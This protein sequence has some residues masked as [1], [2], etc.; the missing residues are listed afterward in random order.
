MP[1]KEEFINYY[2]TNNHSRAETMEYF[3]ISNHYL[4]RCIQEYGCIKHPEYQ[5]FKPEKPDIVSKEELYQYYVIENHTYAETI[6]HFNLGSSS[7]PNLLD[8]YNINKREIIEGWKFNI[9]VQDIY[10]Y[11]IVENHTYKE[12]IDHFNIGHSVFY[13]YYIKNYPELIKPKDLMVEN[14]GKSVLEKYGVKG[15]PI[16]HS[17]KKCVAILKGIFGEGEIIQQYKDERY[18]FK[19]DIYIKKLDLF[20]E[21]NFNWTHGKHR[22]NPDNK[23]DVLLLERW[24]NKSKGDDYYSSAIVVWTER[25]PLKFNIAKKNNL[26][27]LV[28]YNESEFTTWINSIII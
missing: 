8:K 15:F 12:T 19:C 17:E 13:G 2:I 18:P 27:Y 16:S 10:N 23:E 20:I 1:N 3:K 7:L 4:N 6:K 9:P 14:V 11:Y 5:I 24:K 28:F 21:C 26:N 22:F 25:D